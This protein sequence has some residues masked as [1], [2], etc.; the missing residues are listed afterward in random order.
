MFLYPYGKRL[1]DE[2]DRNL[3]CG[4]VVAVHAARFKMIGKVPVGH[5]GKGASC[6]IC[7][8]EYP[9]AFEAE[10]LSR[11]DHVLRLSAFR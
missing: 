10:L 3:C 8:A 6:G 9:A 7:D 4:V 1:Y 5:A 11:P 2:Q